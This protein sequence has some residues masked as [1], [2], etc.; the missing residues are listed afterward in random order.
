MGSNFNVRNESALFRLF[1]LKLPLGK[2]KGKRM[3]RKTCAMSQHF[4][5]YIVVT[6]F[7]CKRQ[8]QVK[9]QTYI[10]NIVKAQQPDSQ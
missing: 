10:G 1:L 7:I 9:Q 6:E 3:I 4:D 5:F 8:F 2:F